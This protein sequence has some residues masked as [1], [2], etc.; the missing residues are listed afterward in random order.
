M[1]FLDF[2]LRLLSSY[3]LYLHV[4]E[5]QISSILDVF[6]HEGFCKTKSD[7]SKKFYEG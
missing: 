6:D 1:S 7:L 5:G 3:R 4:P 2:F